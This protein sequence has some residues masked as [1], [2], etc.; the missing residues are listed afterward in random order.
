MWS[1]WYIFFIVSSKGVVCF[2][3]SGNDSFYTILNSIGW[4]SSICVVYF[5]RLFLMQMGNNNIEYT[6]VICSSI[7][8]YYL[9]KCPSPW[10][11]NKRP[12]LRF[13]VFI[14]QK[15]NLQTTSIL[16]GWKSFFFL[17]CLMYF[18]LLIKT[19]T[20]SQIFAFLKWW[21]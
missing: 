18:I 16:C 21:F 13:L 12:H 1:S 6:Y 19:L 8:K 2:D 14:S 11:C 9:R 15:K 7:F 20:F 10:N 17:L 3:F 5:F 4:V